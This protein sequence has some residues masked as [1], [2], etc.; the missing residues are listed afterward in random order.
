MRGVIA[1][2]LIALKVYRQT[3]EKMGL[4]WA[5]FHGVGVLLLLCLHDCVCIPVTYFSQ[6][7]CQNYPFS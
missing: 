3:G 6:S 5:A 2:M 1:L 4:G 7:M